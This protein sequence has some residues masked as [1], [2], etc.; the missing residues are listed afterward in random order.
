MFKQQLYF[1][2]NK[3]ILKVKYHSFLCFMFTDDSNK[4]I[5][6]TR[7]GKKTCPTQ[8]ELIL[9]GDLIPFTTT[10]INYKYLKDS[11]FSVV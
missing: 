11:L 2:L 7:W 5:V 8:A 6:Y 4:S 9:S 1:N 10:T 3:H